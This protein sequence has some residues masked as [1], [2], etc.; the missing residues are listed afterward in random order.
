MSDSILYQNIFLVVSMLLFII[1][2]ASLIFHN[3]LIK[4]PFP[5]A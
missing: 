1:G 2:L 3:N 5:C 4:K